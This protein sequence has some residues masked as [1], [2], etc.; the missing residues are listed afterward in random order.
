MSDGLWLDPASY[1]FRD[2]SIRPGA[3]F[4]CLKQTRYAPRGRMPEKAAAH[5]EFPWLCAGFRSGSAS[6][7][8]LRQSKR[9]LVRR[10]LLQDSSR[11][12]NRSLVIL[13]L[14]CARLRMVRHRYVGIKLSNGAQPRPSPL[15]TVPPLLFSLRC[16][17]YNPC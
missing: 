11:N 10:P 9:A 15:W 8:R 13:M 5:Y 3:H 17:S 7:T 16:K 14:S 4:K 6:N 12:H 2:E 1:V